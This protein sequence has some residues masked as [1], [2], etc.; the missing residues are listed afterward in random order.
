MEIKSIS[1]NDHSPEQK[2][3]ERNN[4]FQQ[5]NNNLF[6][7]IKV[8]LE[9]SLSLFLVS[10]VLDD[11]ARATDDLTGFSL[12]VVLA[13]SAPLS[14]DLLIGNLDEWDVVFL[15]KSLDELDVLLFVTVLGQYAEMSLSPEKI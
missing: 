15:A 1:G 9:N 7:G 8:L 6:L 4:S 10:V 13:E 2:A 14:D 11:G 3:D 12:L 5:N